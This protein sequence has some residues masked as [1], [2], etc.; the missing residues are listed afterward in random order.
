MLGCKHDRRDVHGLLPCILDR[1]LALAVRAEERCSLATEV[2]EA[3]RQLVREQD[4]ERHELRALVDRVAEHEPLVARALFSF[5]LLF[6]LIDTL[7]DI[8]ALRVDAHEHLDLLQ[9]VEELFRIADVLERRACD[10]LIVELRSRCHLAR[11]H[12]ALRR[13]E[14]LDRDAR[15]RILPQRFVKDCIADLV[16]ALVRM[17][18]GD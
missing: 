13:G 2:A 8:G 10:R 9:V 16:A 7:C 5:S 3:V 17:P 1:H 15:V 14:R 11:H 6:M 18:L 4:R 12:D